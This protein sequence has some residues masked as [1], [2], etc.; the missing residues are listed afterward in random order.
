[1]GLRKTRPGKPKGSSIK[2]MGTTPSG[3]LRVLCGQHPLVSCAFHSR[4][5]IQ[6]DGLCTTQVSPTWHTA[7]NPHRPRRHYPLRHSRNF[8]PRPPA[9]HRGFPATFRGAPCLPH[10][11]HPPPRPRIVLGGSRLLYPHS[12]RR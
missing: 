12:C 9:L 5:E 10:P 1:M 3:C 11:P 2:D 6:V 7:I 8:P 4:S